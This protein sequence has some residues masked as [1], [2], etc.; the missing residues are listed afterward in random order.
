MKKLYLFLALGFVLGVNAQI[1]QFQDAYLKNL[2]VSGTTSYS[3]AYNTEGRYMR[4]DDNGDGE[5]EVYEA[6][7]VKSLQISYYT[8]G[9]THN[10]YEIDD[11]GGLEYFTNL[12]SLS[13]GGH[14]ISSIDFRPFVNLR[15]LYCE[16]GSQLTSLNVSGLIHLETL[17]C[18]QNNL[19]ALDI[20][21]LTA[22][23]SLR[24]SDNNLSSINLPVINQ[25]LSLDCSHNN[26]SN[27]S[28]A[29]LN[30]LTQLDCSHN[31]FS[32]LNFTGLTS[33]TS[34]DCGT[35]NLTTLNV[36]F[37][38]STLTSLMFGNN[39]IASIDLSNSSNLLVLDCS[40]NP[41]GSTISFPNLVNLSSLECQNMGLTSLD[42]SYYPEL[43][44]LNC[45]YNQLTSLN[46]N[47]LNDLSELYCYNNLLT[48]LDVNNLIHLNSLFFYYN[49]IGGS[50]D[51]STLTNLNYLGCSFN[52]LSELF[53]K[54][55]RNEFQLTIQNCPN[56]RYICADESQVASVQNVINQSG[57]TICTTNSYCSFNPGGNYYT[58]LGTVKYDI[59]S[60]GCSAS[61][62]NYPDLR[63]SFG[64][65]S[66]TTN[67]IT[68]HSGT[69]SYAL[70][71]GNHIV[72]PVIQ[73]SN[74]FQVT[75]TSFTVN[76][77]TASNPFTQNICIVPNGNHNDLE[78]SMYAPPYNPAGI[79]GFTASYK[80]KYKNKGTTTQSGSVFLNINDTIF[81]F[82]SSTPLISNQAVGT[83]TWN[84]TDL[85][86][87]ETREIIVYLRLNSPMDLPAVNIG[88]LLHYNAVIYPLD[89][90]EA[91]NDN[92]CDLTIVASNSFDPN[93]KTCLEGNSIAPEKVGDYI[94]Y[95]IRFEN[96]GTGNAQNIVVKDMIDTTKFDI[97]SLI[98]V[99]GSHSFVTKISQTNKVEFIFENI[100]LPFDDA[101]NDGYV[102]FKIK[103]KPTLVVGNT[104]SNTASIYFDYNFPIVTNTATTA[105]VTLAN[106][107]FEFSNYI[108][109][110][111][112]PAN[113][114]LNIQVKEDIIVTSIRI[115]NALG[116]LVLL[117]PNAAKVENIDVSDLRTGSYFIKINSN[118]G[119]ANSKF[120]KE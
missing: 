42:L 120:I 83:L 107:D 8:S 104:F 30:L 33:I 108:S 55:G 18:N 65:G 118:R 73:N 114:V 4:V 6:L 84:F 57:N 74:Y 64:Q 93:D 91:P 19:S 88:D 102:I 40:G 90:D 20:S 101:N 43:R 92:S 56:L 15:T 117:V 24:C 11:L 69:Y 23:R 25:L 54:N 32:N 67:L 103:T 47:H 10:V 38:N 111:P 3:V 22:L 27:L 71:A 106:P 39:D 50:V 36:G 17:G 46:V 31:N 2:L 113:N 79:P 82:V 116:Q 109:L 58:V 85:H 41:I 21:S 112:N 68:N 62:V 105:V 61:D 115:Y 16:S 76:F 51:L 26:L 87:F 48:S 70:T 110:F 119:N 99:D 35:N 66:L 89:N 5:I 72:T 98:P 28:F 97:S 80:I 75:P 44:S 34:I 63:L 94:H 53:I 77:P 7:Q 13:C 49:Q 96:T 12:E 95:M 78:I 100:N 59:N 14:P 1:I 86:P 52:P 37:L 9:N 45:S 60:D 29:N 81:D